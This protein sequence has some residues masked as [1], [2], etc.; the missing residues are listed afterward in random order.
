MKIIARSLLLLGGV[1]ALYTGAYT[2]ARAG[3]ERA[4][5]HAAL[6]QATFFAL[7]GAGNAGALETGMQMFAAV[8]GVEIQTAP[9]FVNFLWRAPATETPNAVLLENWAVR[10]FSAC[11]AAVCGSLSLRGL[12][13]HGLGLSGAFLPQADLR[14]TDLSGSD[15]SEADLSEADLSGANLTGTRLVGTRLRYTNFLD[16]Q[17]MQA[18][19]Q[20]AN[21]SDAELQGV[22]LGQVNLQWTEL[23]RANLTEANLAGANLYGADLREAKLKG[24]KLPGAIL[25]GVDLIGAGLIEADLQGAD[26]EEADL[27]E[28]K[29]R[30]ANLAG[31]NLKAANLHKSQSVSNQP[32]QGKTCWR[33]SVS[34]QS[35]GR[36]LSRCRPERSGIETGGLQWSQSQGSQ[37]DRGQPG[38][39][40]IIRRGNRPPPLNGTRNGVWCGIS[41]TRKAK[42]SVWPAQTCVTLPGRR[43]LGRR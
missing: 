3:H 12:D 13:L 14:G 21:L 5:Q 36:N 31:A 34:N 17:L 20:S 2:L 38:W 8:R 19:L 4:V 43:D 9:R 28:A 18:D 35:G 23:N 24:V 33:G 16:A 42:W 1:L 27:I 7:V 15:L 30:G 29:L 39:G 10:F 37:L 6:K 22:N 40:R 32:Y 26:L 25:V 41:S 11:E